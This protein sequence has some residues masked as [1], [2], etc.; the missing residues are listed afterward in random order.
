MRHTLSSTKIAIG[1]V[2]VVAVTWFG[3]KFITGWMINR[4]EFVPIAPGSVN[5]VGVDTSAGYYIVVANETAKLVRGDIGEFKPGE[6]EESGEGGEKR[7]VPIREMLR[8]LQGDEKALGKFVMSLNDKSDAEF[9][10]YPIVWK[11]E[12]LKKAIEGDAQLRGKLE[13][14]LNVK[15]DGTPV[16]QIKTSTLESGIIL[17]LPVPVAVR[18][19]SEMK[20][21]VARVQEQFIPRLCADVW[22]QIREKPNLSPE[23]I[24]GNYLEVGRR[25]LE[26]P[27]ERQD[28]KQAIETRI[29]P[30]YLSRMADVPKRVLESAQVIINESLIESAEYRSYKTSDG[31]TSFDIVLNV[32]DEGR[33]RLWQFSK[34]NPNAQ[35]L[36]TWE[37]IAIA[38]PRIQGELA[39]SNVT[40][41]QLTDEGLVQEAVDAI[42][43]L[44]TDKP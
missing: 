18:V 40:V 2:V 7:R 34:R 9:P 37:G 22:S 26:N 6:H 17:D 32:S 24:K 27:S 36:V 41:K 11:A 16:D 29:D 23:I 38:A 28:V 13:K 20:N 10:A 25:V 8:S 15:L 39:L 5:L 1:F 31:K 3:W 21:L 4:I 33:Q 35:L 44:K 14:D 30:Q 42:N 43:R 12:D 19:G